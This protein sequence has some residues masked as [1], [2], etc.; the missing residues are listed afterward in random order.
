MCATWLDF[1]EKCAE[2]LL[3]HSTE[4]CSSSS[5]SR[6]DAI[7]VSRRGRWRKERKA[8]DKIPSKMFI[9]FS[10]MKEKT[11]AYGGRGRRDKLL[12]CDRKQWGLWKTW[13]SFKKKKHIQQH[14][15]H[16]TEASVY[17]EGLTVCGIIYHKCIKAEN[18]T[19]RVCKSKNVCVA[20]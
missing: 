14:Y 5:K 19:L 3:R 6:A 15:W 8:D 1:T 13:T 4:S 18:A 12:L 11:N 17:T 9:L 10:K 20:C 2:P 7:R 16:E